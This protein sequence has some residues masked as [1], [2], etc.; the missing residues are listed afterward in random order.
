MRSIDEVWL[1]MRPLSLRRWMGEQPA[2]GSPGP[3]TR[4]RS[5]LDG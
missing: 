2:T 4:E 5:R 3:S 1:D